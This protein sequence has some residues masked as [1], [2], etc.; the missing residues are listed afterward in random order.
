MVESKKT[1]TVLDI[2]TTKVCAIQASVDSTF[3]FD[4]H[5]VSSKNSL[6]MRK[7]NVVD[8]QEVCQSI[9]S[10]LDE[11]KSKTGK[12]I[13]KVSISL[14]GPHIYSFNHSSTSIL[15]SGEVTKADIR[16]TVELSKVAPIPKDREIIH[17]IP[18]KFKVDQLDSLSNPLGLSGEKIC[19][20]MHIVTA[21]KAPVHNLVKSVELAGYVVENMYL[22]PICSSE[23]VLTLEEKNLGVLLVDIGGGTTDLALWKGGHIEHTEIIPIG[24]NHFTRDLSIALNVPLD[25]AEKIKI[26]YGHLLKD[27]SLEDGSENIKIYGI[28]GVKVREASFQQIREVLE[29]RSEELFK[30][31]SQSIEDKQL[32]EQIVGGIVLTGGGS[33]LK[34]MQEYSEFQLE[35]PTKMGIPH[36]IPGVQT[37]FQNPKF[38]TVVGL[39]LEVRKRLMNA[40]EQMSEGLARRDSFYKFKESIRNVLRDFF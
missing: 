36:S 27:S 16:K 13:D 8:I 23:A 15:K 18:Q 30:M 38:S 17:Y 33:L 24:G 5:A 4:I 6:G 11:I 7:G 37:Y 12:K 40:D 2:G 21:L 1:I 9:K 20:Q 39:L 22:Q 35:K 29:A 3:T 31:I 28:D 25:E 14:A 26:K 19:G 34:G 32:K 10:C